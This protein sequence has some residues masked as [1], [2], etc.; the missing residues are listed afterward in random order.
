[1]IAETKVS[2]NIMQ[3]AKADYQEILEASRNPPTM[4]RNTESQV[5]AKLFQVG[6]ISSRY[7]SLEDKQRESLPL[8]L[9]SIDIQEHL[10]AEGEGD[11]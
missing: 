2:L 9:E 5:L 8:L 11:W 4:N 1:M 10:S 3:D 7:I 6:V